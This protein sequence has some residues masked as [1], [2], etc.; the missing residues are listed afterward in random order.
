MLFVFLISVLIWAQGALAQQPTCGLPFKNATDVLGCAENRSPEVQKALLELE[1]A[2]AQIGASEQWRNPELSID[3]VSGSDGKSE[4]GVNLGIPIELGG[5]LDARRN[6]AKS[7]TTK[8]EATLYAAKT[9]VRSSV[10]LKL[11]RLRQLTHEQEV[12]DESIDTFTKLVKQYGQRFKLSPEQEISVTVFKM[13]KSEYELKKSELLAE[14]NLLDAFFQT[15]IGVGLGE[16]QSVVPKSPKT[17][18][19]LPASGTSSESPKLKL[20]SA[21]IERAKAELS[22][23]ASEAWPTVVL[24]PSIKMQ[25]ESGRNNQLYGFNLS[26]PL[27]IFNANGKGKAAA[28][29]GLRVAETNHQLAQLD[30]QKT[31][32][33]LAKTYQQSVTVLGTTVSHEEI[34]KKHDSIEKLFFRGVVPSSLVIEAHRTYVDLEKARNERELKTLEAL[35]AIYAFDGKLLEVQ[36]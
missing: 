7:G 22:L 11:H 23:A 5:K 10:L 17:W 4:T 25:N 26:L 6:V 35:F 20:T 30:L 2:K 29:S 13:S 1:Q 8:A 32:E 3:S 15:V 36:Q 28:A 21:E 9:E 31:R 19:A 33:Q 14:R 12:I 16:L 24:G 34:E 27:P 18:P